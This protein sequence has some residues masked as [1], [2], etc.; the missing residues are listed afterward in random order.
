MVRFASE[1]IV[2]CLV[3]SLIVIFVNFVAVLFFTRELNQILS[4]LS[5]LILVEG[6]LGLTV[7]GS[8]AVYSPI[9]NKIGEVLFHSPPW[10]AKRQKEAEKQA[11]P[12]IVTGAILV[13]AALLLSAL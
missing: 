5:F 13:L 9:G 11:R 2:T 6:G 10:N 3:Y 4:T 8:T 12:W 7:G 1:L